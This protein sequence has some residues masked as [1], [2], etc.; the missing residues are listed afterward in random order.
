MA[1]VVGIRFKEN[2][3]IYYFDPDSKNFSKGEN[4][5]VETVR[6]IECGEIATPNHTVAEEEIR[7][8]LK[9]IIR[10][11]NAED[12]KIVAA[13]HKKE[14]EAFDFCEKKVEQLGL[15]MKLVE[16]ECTFDGSK[17]LF[18]FTSDDRVDF[19]ELVKI[20]ASQYRTRIEMRQIG[21]RDVSKMIGGLGICG[22]PFCCSQFLDD[23]HPVSIKMAKEQGLSL[24]PSKI[25]GTCGRLLCC[26][27][28]EQDS[29]EYLNKITP[30]VGSIV[31][32]KEG[33]GTVV[34]SN[35]LTGKLK[36]SLER[37]PEALPSEYTRKEVKLVK[38]QKF[39]DENTAEAT[40][41]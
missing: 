11:A 23:F 19:R 2:G 26:L 31:D 4:V 34:E 9:K 39:N 6:G 21:V 28:Y 32:T 29:Y 17:M 14:A 36:V 5:I 41:E 37:R 18:Y 12:I 1:E 33:R 8:P 35:L 15:D 10:G 40:E 24:N 13:N 3:K 30:R 16:V 22:R 27:K 25:S 20:L 7:H 38:R